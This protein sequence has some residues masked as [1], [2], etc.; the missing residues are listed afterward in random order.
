M[1][2]KYS[3]KNAFGHNTCGLLVVILEAIQYHNYLHNTC[4]KLR[5]ISNLDLKYMGGLCKLYTNAT[6]LYV[7]DLSIWGF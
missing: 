5:I 6:S 4:I 1:N 2:W 3:E 7:R